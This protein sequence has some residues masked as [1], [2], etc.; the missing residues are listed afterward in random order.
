MFK[1]I[2]KFNKFVYFRQNLYY[3]LTPEMAHERNFYT[4]LAPLDGPVW[5]VLTLFLLLIATLLKFFNY[6]TRQSEKE[7]EQRS[8]IFLQ[9]IGIVTNQG[10]SDVPHESSIRILTLSALVMILVLFNLYT[11]SLLTVILTP[12]SDTFKNAEELLQNRVHLSRF[13]NSFTEIALKVR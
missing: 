3:L 12:P 7:S 13:N 10:L 11:A 5:I 4:F 6:I 8:S 9:I 2:E 1:A